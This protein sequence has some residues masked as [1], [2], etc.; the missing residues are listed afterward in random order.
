MVVF[1]LA[2]A[3]D[4][5]PQLPDLRLPGPVPFNVQTFKTKFRRLWYQSQEVPSITSA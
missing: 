2:A 5:F 4:R 3:S 1:G